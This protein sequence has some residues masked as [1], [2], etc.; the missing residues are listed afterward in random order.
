VTCSEDL[1]FRAK[2]ALGAV[3]DTRPDIFTGL[4]ET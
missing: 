1:W 2:D 3:A 4:D